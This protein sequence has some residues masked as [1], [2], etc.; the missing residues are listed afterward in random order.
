MP[1]KT[2]NPAGE[3]PFL[4]HLEELRWRILWSLLAL[5][6]GAVAGFLLVH[7]GDMLQVLFS[8]YRALF[9]EDQTLINLKPTDA[10]FI[11]LKYGIL[12][13][14]LLV[15]PI[16]VYHV[17]SFLAP[18]L[19]KS[20]KRV[21]VPSLYMGLVLFIF[22]VLMAYYIALPIT[23]EFLVGFQTEI[24]SP[25]WTAQDYFGFTIQLL[26]A[27]G[28]IFEL[29]VVVMILSVLGLVTPKFLRAKRRHAILLITIVAALISPGDVIMVTLL[30]MVPL[31][32]LYEFSIMLSVM[33][34]RKREERV[35][36][37]ADPPPDSV[38]AG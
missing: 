1:S 22:G 26:V 35:A 6:I 5:A 9:G 31:I 13:G 37:A 28:I 36:A 7:Y 30:M 4:D 15:F 34:Y 33:I 14:F 27:F 20:E 10:F 32:I 2:P 21:I 3:M 38:Q 8:P 24:M 16:I 11:T 23:L 18:A 12:I 17:W 29:P 19:K 25:Q